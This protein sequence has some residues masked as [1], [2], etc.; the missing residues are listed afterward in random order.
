M[1]HGVRE[2][3]ERRRE[4]GSQERVR[5]HR[6]RRVP[7]EGVDEVVQGR[8]KDGEEA[9]AHE[10][11]PDAG[12]EPEYLRVGRPSED[13]QAS[14]E[15]ERSAHHWWE[16]G[17]GY[18]SVVVCH[19]ASGVEFVVPSIVRLK[20]RR[21]GIIGALTLCLQALLELFQVKG[22]GTGAQKL[23]LPIF[24]VQQTV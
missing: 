1:E 11:E 18:G 13:E 5:R 14:C 21:E 22:Q 19:E 2:Q 15:E 7:L 10:H 20:H 23:P 3:R 4:D 12:R 24:G 9:E 8:L 16:A 17:F 6:A